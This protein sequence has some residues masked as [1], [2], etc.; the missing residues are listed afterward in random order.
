[1]AIASL[2][3][4]L[5][6]FL[7]CGLT[8]IAGLILGAIDWSR[9]RRGIS[10][11]S[12]LALWGFWLSTVMVVAMV[13]L[14]LLALFGFILQQ[15]SGPRVWADRDGQ[16]QY[17]V[18]SNWGEGQEL[19]FRALIQYSDGEIR[20][21]REPGGDAICFEFNEGGRDINEWTESY[22]YILQ[23]RAFRLSDAEALAQTREVVEAWAELCPRT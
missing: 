11:K 13:A 1:M 16:I 9:Q 3:L 23:R 21:E 18:P 7:T 5:L 8:S 10:V 22:V 12:S 6:G 17:T 20:N 2:V 15:A 19:V 4:A 14:G